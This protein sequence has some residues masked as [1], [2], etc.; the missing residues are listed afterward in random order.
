MRHM[1]NNI[2]LRGYQRYCTS[3]LIKMLINGLTVNCLIDIN[4]FVIKDG[5]NFQ[6]KD[7]TTAVF[8]LV[9]I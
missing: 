6:L 2:D 9:H 1:R 5:L 4:G 3:I 8:K 7:G